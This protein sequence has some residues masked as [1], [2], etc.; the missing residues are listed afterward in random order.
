MIELGE[1]ER[2]SQ[3]FADL[4]VTVI[5]VSLDDLEIAAEV[6]R[7]FPSLLAVSDHRREITTGLDL[8]MRSPTGIGGEVVAPT[9][10]L[11]DAQGTVRW[12]YRPENI[13]ERLSTQE[14]LARVTEHF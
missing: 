9:T 11:V 10:L 5:C 13:I 12:L 7:R 6:Q 14:V 8:L 3:R 1:F 2:E 4:G